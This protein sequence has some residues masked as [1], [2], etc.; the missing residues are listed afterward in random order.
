MYNLIDVTN[1]HTRIKLI[2]YKN[3]NMKIKHM[4]IEG[5]SYSYSYIPYTVCNSKTVLSSN[6]IYSIANTNALKTDKLYNNI[7]MSGRPVDIRETVCN[8][9]THATYRPTSNNRNEF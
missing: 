9:Y 1:L 6:N 7:T 5:E 3:I 8:R 2:N 4:K